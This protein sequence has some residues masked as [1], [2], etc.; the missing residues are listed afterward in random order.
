MQNHQSVI[1][2]AHPTTAEQ[3]QDGVEEY[4]SDMRVAFVIPLP[5]G[6]GEW[7]IQYAVSA[8][9]EACSMGPGVCGGVF[10]L[11]GHF[12]VEEVSS[13]RKTPVNLCPH[14]HLR[15]QTWAFSAL[16]SIKATEAHM[17]SSLPSAPTITRYE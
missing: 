9:S 10:G 16:S 12:G 2:R 17:S 5:E 15:Q 8:P 13:L 11:E 4:L 3:L 1:L 6:G 7:K 14:C